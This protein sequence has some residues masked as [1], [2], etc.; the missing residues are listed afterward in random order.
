MGL[1]GG[2]WSSLQFPV[3]PR[4]APSPIWFVRPI[5]R[6]IRGRWDSCDMACPNVSSCKN[7]VGSSNNTKFTDYLE[8][9][10][11]VLYASAYVRTTLVLLTGFDKLPRAPQGMGQP[12]KARGKFSGQP[13]D[14][15]R[16]GKKA[17][18]Q[19]MAVTQGHTGLVRQLEPL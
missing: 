17:S 13:R 15:F 16:L 7:R 9:R 2:T 19:H 12:A 18:G 3:S 5:W 4:C 1:T 6:S 10:L 8:Y 11:G 14:C